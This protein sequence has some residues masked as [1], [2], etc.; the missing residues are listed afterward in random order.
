M[1]REV[2]RGLLPIE[3]IRVFQYSDDFESFCYLDKDRYVIQYSTMMIKEKSLLENLD[4]QIGCLIHECGHC[5]FTIFDK[6]K[7]NF[8][9]TQSKLIGVPEDWLKDVDNIYEDV[10]IENRLSTEI[11]GTGNYLQVTREFMMEKVREDLKETK[12]VGLRSLIFY[13]YNDK[14]VCDELLNSKK[15]IYG[16]TWKEIEPIIL[17]PKSTLDVHDLTIKAARTLKKEELERLVKDEMFDRLI[18]QIFEAMGRSMI[19]SAFDQ[20]Q[21]KT[22]RDNELR[23]TNEETNKSTGSKSLKFTEAKTIKSSELDQNKDKAS[24][25]RDSSN[26]GPTNTNSDKR[27]AS[28]K[29]S[30]EDLPDYGSE[31]TNEPEYIPDNLEQSFL[32]TDEVQEGLVDQTVVWY[33]QKVKEEMRSEYD[34]IAQRVAPDA[35]VLRSIFE[36]YNVGGWK[37]K[38]QLES[39]KIDRRFIHRVPLDDQRVFKQME[40]RINAPLDVITLIDE[41][42]SMGGSKYIKAREVAILIHEALYKIPEINFWCYGHTTHS[43]G[44]NCELHIYHEGKVTDRMEKYRLANI[45]AYSGNCDGRAI[46]EAASRVYKR[47]DHKRKVLMILISDGLPTESCPG[48]R[49]DEFAKRAAL[50]VERKMGFE[51]IHV[52]IECSNHSL[53]K[54]SI[55]YVNNSQLTQVIGQLV[56]E[57]IQKNRAKL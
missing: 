4:I 35:A 17:L 13:A 40:K 3:K 30:I 56:S 54:H 29:E 11:I 2:I 50:E 51:F 26:R 1:E 52:G 42:G 10:H 19:K 43:W 22:D 53:Y 32:G 7:P 16:Y 37:I 31:A 25:D 49:P 20:M 55:D 38:S 57:H 33:K 36:K 47:I 5:I 48:L 15:N 14:S 12:E 18:S 24:I 8:Y 44:N 6:D 21:E 27:V 9:E 45:N 28:G 34:A 41:S 46:L 23:R 39:G